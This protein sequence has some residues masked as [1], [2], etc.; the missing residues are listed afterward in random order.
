MLDTD[1]EQE[2]NIWKIITVKKITFVKSFNYLC[3]R[4][5]KLLS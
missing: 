4:I 1:R 3:W 5:R 2:K